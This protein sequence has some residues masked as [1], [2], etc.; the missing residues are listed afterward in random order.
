MAHYSIG[1]DSIDLI[2]LGIILGSALVAGVTLLSVWRWAGPGAVKRC[3][4]VFLVI[5]G[6]SAIDIH[7]GFKSHY[8]LV[9]QAA[10]I[11]ALYAC[12][13]LTTIAYPLESNKCET[14][15]DDG[16]PPDIQSEK[17]RKLKRAA[18]FAGGLVIVFAG[19]AI[20][21]YTGL[22]SQYPWSFWAIH[23]LSL[24]AYAYLT[25]FFESHSQGANPNI[26]EDDKK[27]LATS[28][29]E[30]SEGNL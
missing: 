5:W 26:L 1:I 7:T 20:D 12:H 16:N 4:G 28:R 18:G 22:K 21:Q 10:T 13:C 14:R 19:E 3:I 17:T 27:I 29:T 8:P 23:L 30:I 6:M 24:T 9:F 2:V 25:A 11:L 15:R